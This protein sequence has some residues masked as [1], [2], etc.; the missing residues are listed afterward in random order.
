[1]NEGWKALESA[2]ARLHHDVESA[3]AKLLLVCIPAAV[4]VD[5]TYW[6]PKK[7]GVRFDGRV[8]HDT[9]FQDRLTKFAKQEQLPLIDLLPEMRKRST[10][11]LYYQQDGH[12]TA[13]GHDVAARVIAERLS[14]LLPPSNWTE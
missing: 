3:H 5:S 9:V 6:W 12:W 7:L 10:S 14:A 11:R 13:A 8:L 1:M 4:Q 2:L